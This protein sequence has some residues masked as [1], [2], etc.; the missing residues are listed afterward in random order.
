MTSPFLTIAHRA[1]EGVEARRER[2]GLVS[3]ILL[4]AFGPGLGSFSRPTLRRNC[5]TSRFVPAEAAIA[6]PSKTSLRGKGPRR[7]TSSCERRRFA[8]TKPV[9]D[10]RSFRLRSID[11]GG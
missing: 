9:Q 5:R 7:K 2:G 4:E 10:Q 6:V 1:V 3:G 11:R 8:Q